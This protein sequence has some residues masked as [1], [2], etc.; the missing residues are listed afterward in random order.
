MK[1]ISCTDAGINRKR[2]EIGIEA[3]TFKKAC[4]DAFHKLSSK[5]SIPGFR[6]GKAPRNVIDRVYGKGFFYEEA[7][8]ALYP[9]AV[10]AAIEESKI[11]Y[12]DDE[13]GLEII[14]VNDEDGLVFAAEVTVR[15]EVKLPEYKGIKVNKP[16][17][18]VTDEDVDKKLAEMREKNFRTVDVDDRPV[19][20][21]DTVL[22]DFEGF[23]DDIAF[24]GGKGENYNLVIGSGSFIPGFEEQ[25]IGHTIGEDFDVNVTFPEDYN[26]ENLKGK[27]AVFKCRVNKIEVKEYFDLDDE[28]AKD[29]GDADTLEELKAK[30]REELTAQKEKAAK[31]SIDNQFINFIIDEMECVVPDVMIEKRLDRSI[32]DYDFNLRQRGITLKEYT[33]Y[34]G[35]TA[36]QF[37]DYMR[38]QAEGH[39]KMRLAF[40]EIAKLEGYTATEE[41]IEA[42]YKKLADVYD[43]DLEKVK[44]LIAADALTEDIVVEKAINMVRE[45]AEITETE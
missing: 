43:M 6:K 27:P 24:E 14:S 4:D 23:V 9:D 30:L 35:I 26:A 20:D 44:S 33:K 13:V 19:Q 18:V 25:I 37:R 29:F 15:P 8:K 12:I 36:E 42:E 34:I 45:N 22:L 38:P 5:I 7:L 17:V 1:L 21:G 16:S 31:D 3:E 39:V 32:S 11:Q 40:E 41:E 28:F 10:T 2:L